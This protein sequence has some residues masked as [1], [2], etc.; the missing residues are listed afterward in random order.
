MS[1]A[2]SGSSV[3]ATGVGTTTFGAI[4]LANPN[5]VTGSLP[6][7]N[8]SYPLLFKQQNMTGSNGSQPLSQAQL[9]SSILT[10]VPGSAVSAGQTM[11]IDFNANV[12]SWWLDCAQLSIG[13]GGGISVKNGTT[14]N[15]KGT[16]LLTTKD[17]L[18]VVCVQANSCSLG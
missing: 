12:G 5:A 2:L 3:L 7:A 16:V 10:F 8:L 15:T 4:D 6:T 1:F 9:S 17:V 14:T 18:M 11:T 13:A